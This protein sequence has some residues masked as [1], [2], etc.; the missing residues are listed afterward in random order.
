MRLEETS[1]RLR[2]DR[3]KLDRLGRN[4]QIEPWR[5]FRDYY[6]FGAPEQEL[7]HELLR[8]GRAGLDVSG[9]D[10]VVVA[11]LEVVPDRRIEVMAVDF[12]RLARQRGHA[13]LPLRGEA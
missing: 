11:E 6:R 13:G 7:A 3:R 5:G 8:P 2:L 4:A 1:V 12:A 9:D 10:D